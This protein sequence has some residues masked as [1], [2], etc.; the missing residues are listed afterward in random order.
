MVK[1]GKGLVQG[2]SFMDHLK[3]TLDS[4]YNVSITENGAVGYRT[5]GKKLLDLNFQV[6]SLRNQSEQ[7]VE[8]RFAEVFCEN[9]M[10]A[11]K[12]LFYAGDVRGGL[13]ERRLFRIG[14]TYLAKNHPKLA[15]AVLELIPFYS[16]WDNL[17]CLLDTSLC[18]NVVGLIKQQLT[19]DMQLMKE[20]KPIS[21]LAKWLPSANASSKETKRL[22]RMIISK[23]DISEKQYRKTLSKLRAYLKV[24]EVSMSKKEWSQINYA[25]VP[26]RA[27]LIYNHAFLRNDEERRRSYLESLK[28]G[29]TKI[30]ASVLFPHDIVNSY[31]DKVGW[32]YQLKPFDDTLEELWKALPNYVSDSGDTICV[33]DGSGSMTSTIGGT[34]VSCLDVANALAIYFAE[35]SSGQFYNSYIT[36]SEHPKLVDLNP[37]AN[38]RGK[39]EIANRHN[40]VA[41]TNIEAVFQLILRVAVKQKMK[42]EDLPQNILIL[43]DMEF[44]S[45][46]TCNSNGRPDERLF[47]TFAR[48]YQEEGYQLPR[49]IFWNICSRTGTIPV[50]ENKLGVILVSGFSPNI[51]K[52]V[53]SNSVDPMEALLEQLQAERYD[54]VEQAIK[55]I[56]RSI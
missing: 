8:N 12:W 6:S 41:N 24:V 11:I 25:A 23:L 21:L 7:E 45:C 9:P 28:K 20:Q 34:K 53:M 33:A 51:M 1:Y 35:R 30:H 47:Q 10:L 49:L 38:L 42:Q 29:E 26:S 5:T 40:E 18:E 50:R 46:A 15:N 32:H 31:Y 56:Y 44:D 4:D 39:L 27:N 13:G 22:A 54:A 43:S 17:L 2:M 52:M 14:I 16:R 55:N 36:F 48:Q 3:E 19:E 37:A